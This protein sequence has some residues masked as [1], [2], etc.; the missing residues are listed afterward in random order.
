MS[1]PDIVSKIKARECEFRSSERKV[2]EL[3][4][5]D[6][7]WAGKAS[8]QEL[9]KKAGVSEATVT[10]FAK[11]VDCKDVRELKQ[12]LVSSYAIGQ[13]FIEGHADPIQPESG[14]VG[15][16][17]QG[18]LKALQQVREQCSQNKI[19]QAA[20]YIHQCKKLVVFGCGGGGTVIAQ[21]TVNR[22]FRFGIEASAHDDHVM[23]RMIAATLNQDC[24]VLVISTTGSIKELNTNAQVAKDYGAKVISITRNDS[25]LA[26]LSD[27][28]L[29]V[30][31]KED[32]GIFKATS[33]R[34]ALLAVMDAIALEVGMK[35]Q[36]SS[37][38][39]LRRIKYNLDQIRGGDKWY[40][41]GD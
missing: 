10:R 19:E 23:Q 39:V 1:S 5:A 27:L 30:H 25:E 28:H 38:E 33:S 9:A 17:I 26:S 32:E 37:K 22:L 41:V 34:Y 29:Q 11:A 24:C 6:L 35:R 14:A 4:L 18:I 8:I 15:Q 7:Q 12:A 16:I 36:D 21:D 31:I 2:A 13:R 20:E 3:I 40:P